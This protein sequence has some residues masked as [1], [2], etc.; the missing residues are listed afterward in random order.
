MAYK[1]FTGKL[2]KSEVSAFTEFTGK[3]D[4]PVA[5]EPTQPAE[6]YGFFDR[7]KQ[8][9]N[10][11]ADIV[12]DKV[13]PRHMGLALDVARGRT[14][15]SESVLMGKVLPEP[16]FNPAEATALS[17]RKYAEMTDPA[18]GASRAP[19][20]RQAGGFDALPD[21][22]IAG[23]AGKLVESFGRG[24]TAG[25]TKVLSDAAGVV[26][27]DQAS[28][29]LD[30][31]TR[32]N[33]RKADIIGRDIGARNEINYAD[34]SRTGLENFSDKYAP[35]ML[36]QLP[37]L[38][39]AL[40]SGGVTVPAVLSGLSAYA[41]AREKGLNPVS[42]AEYATAMGG[43]EAVGEK[44]GGTGKLADAFETALKQ[45]FNKNAVAQLGGLALSTGVKEVPSELVTYSGQSGVDNL[46]NVNP[47]N[48]E[49]FKQGAI[50]TAIVAAGSGAMI[51][52]AGALA[53]RALGG[54]VEPLPAAADI[55]RQKGFLVPD[56]APTVESQPTT[57]I[58]P[59]VE[60]QPTIPVAPGVNRSA[61]TVADPI[62]PMDDAALLAGVPLEEGEAD[63][64]PTVE[65]VTAALAE[66]NA[67]QVDA[68]RVVPEAPSELPTQ[69]PT[70]TTTPTPVIP[71]GTDPRSTLAG[72]MAALKE[73]ATVAKAAQDAQNQQDAQA[74]EQARVTAEQQR[75]SEGDYRQSS[76][77]PTPQAGAVPSPQLVTRMVERAKTTF[78]KNADLQSEQAYPERV[79]YGIINSTDVGPDLLSAARTEL[80]RRRGTP[81][82]PTVSYSGQQSG[83]TSLG[84]APAQGR[85][86]GA[87][88][89]QQPTNVQQTGGN[90]GGSATGAPALSNRASTGQGIDSLPLAQAAPADVFEGVQKKVYQKK[91]VIIKRSQR[92]LTY[93]Q[94]VVSKLA[95]M[96]GKTV[97]WIERAS[98]V[99]TDMPNG[100]V[101]SFE[102]E[103]YF[104]DADST[105]PALEILMHEGV[106]ALPDHIR[107]KLKAVVL[108]NVSA[109]GK[110]EFLKQYGYDKE[111]DTIKDEEV[112]AYVVQNVVK[113][114]EFFQD[115]RKALGNKDFAELAK[116]IVGKIKSWFQNPDQFDAE[117]LGKNIANL[118]E[119]HDAA[120]QAYTQ[121]MQEQGLTPDAAVVEGGP[122]FATKP[123]A[124][125]DYQTIQ[126]K[127]GSMT[128]RG[129]VTEIRALMPDGIQGRATKDGIAFTHSDAP[130]VRHAL[131]GNNTAYSRGGQVTEKLALSRDG[132]YLGA[133][134]QF[135]TPGKIPTLRKLLMKLT[136]EGEAGRFWYENS[137][138]AVLHMVGGDKVE[139][140]KFA[141]LLAIYSPQAKVDTNGTFALR[142]WAQYKAGQPISVKT[143]VM[144]SKAQNAL[145]NVDEYWSGEKTGNF[146]TN[147]LRNIDPELAQGATIDMW[148]MRAAQYSND[149]PTKT[150]YAFMENETNRIA[151]ELGWEPQQVQAA[152]W[153]AMKA[154]MEND[155]VKK[156]VE[157]KSEKKGWIHY[158]YPLK[159]GK[160]QK[161]R[162]IDN[163]A[164]HRQNWIDQAMAYDPS[165]NDTQRAKFDFEDSLLRHIGLISFEARPGRN[166]GVLPGIHDA[167]Y[168]RQLEF[169][170]AVQSAMY[171]EDGADMLAA[172][173]GLM[174]Y[175]ET[176]VPGVWQGEVS[177]ST[178]KS[179]AMAPTK[180][181]EGKPGVDAAQKK[182]LNAYAAI[183]G[184]LT[185]QD[186]VGWHRPFYSATRGESNGIDIDMGRPVTPEEAGAT[187]KAVGAWMT[188][189]GKDMV[190]DGAGGKVPWNQRFAFVSSPN[191]IRLI[192]FGAVTNLQLQTV[193]AKTL[194][195]VLPDAV[196]SDW[197]KSDGEMPENN[198]KDH[199]DGSQYIARASAEGASDVLGWARTVLGERIQGVFNEY[200][201][202]YGWGDPG[203]IAFS[204][205]SDRGSSPDIS[206][207]VLR[208]RADS[209]GGARGRQSADG[210]LR[211][212][213]QEVKALP[214]APNV[215]GFHGP[216]PRLVSVAH[217]YADANGINLKRQSEYAKV[218][219]DRA[220]RIADAYEAMPHAPNDPK[221]KA[222]YTNLIR[223]TIAQYEALTAAGYKFWFMDMSRED[224]QEY[225]G[226]PW[227]AMRD[228][229]ANKVMG[230]FPTT[231]GFGSADKVSD[232][233]LETTVTPFKWPS[234]GMNGPM[235]PVLANDL[236]RAVH[237]AFGHGLEGAGFRAEGEENAWQAHSR[238]FTGTAVHAITTETRG[239]NSW[240][241]YGPHGDANKNAKVEDTHFADQKIG[242]MPSWTWTEGV[243]GDAP[244]FSNKAN[245]DTILDAAGV[246]GKERLDILRDLRSGAI[247]EEDLAKA[248]PETTAPVMSNKAQTETDAF[249]KWFGDSKVVDADGKPLASR[250]G[251]VL[252][253]KAAMSEG[254][255]DGDTGNA[256]PL[257]DLLVSK[258]FSLEG[259]GGLEVPSQREVLNGVIA[260]GDNLEV[261][262]SVV[263][264]IPVDVMNILARKNVT[265]E[266]LFSDKA[267]LKELL[268]I[269]SDGS[270][271]TAVKVA[272][273]LVAAVAGVA[274]KRS[275]ISTDPFG[276]PNEGDSTTAASSF[277]EFHGGSIKPTG[278]NGDY[279][280]ANPDIRF[281]RSGGLNQ[282][283]PAPL[284]E[285]TNWQAFVRTMQDKYLHVEAI[286]NTLLA[287]G[288]TVGEQQ[289][290]YRAEERMHG[291]AQEKLIDFGRNLLEPLLEKAAK[292]GIELNE[293][294][295]YAYAR[296]A[297]ERNDHIDTINPALQG[298]GSGMDNATAASIMQMVQLT[299]DQAK[300]D[301]LQKD[302]MKLT[303]ATRQEYLKSGLISQDEYDGWT[304]TY[305]NYVPLRG[306]ENVDSEGMAKPGA[307]SGLSVKGK[308]T[309]KALGRRSRAGDIIE[310]IVAEHERAVLRGERN[311][312]AKTL[313]NLVQTNPDPALWEVQPRKRKAAFNRKTGLVV[314]QNTPDTADSVGAKVG[315]QQVYIKVKDPLLLRALTNEGL[316]KKGAL[317]GTVV[318]YLGMYTNLLRNTLTRYNPVFGAVNAVRDA[319]MGALSTY[320]TLGAKGV[321]LYAKYYKQAFAAAGRH[322]WGSPNMAKEMDRWLKEMRLAGGTTSGVFMR[323][324]NE[325]KSDLRTAMLLGGASPVG[326]RENL[327]VKS[328][329]AVK[330]AQAVGRVLEWMGA[331]SEDAARLAAYRA[332]R[333]LGKTPA[334][335]ASIAKNL[336]TNFNRS[337]EWGASINGLYL[338]FNAGVQG[339]ARLG[340]ALKNPKVRYV[341]AAGTAAAMA[342]ALAGAAAGGEDDDGVPYW[343]QIPDYEKERNL[344]IMLPPGLEMDGAA[345]VGK[346]GKYIKIP[347]QYGLNVFMTFGYQL[348][349]LARNM[350][351]PARGVT[352]GKAA[353]NMT[354]VTLGSVNPFGGSLDP[355]EP[356]Q[357]GM[358]L[359]PTVGDTALQL[360]A[361]VNA[362]GKPVGPAKGPYDTKP[363]S[364]TY[365]ATQAGSASQRL[366]EWMNTAT[367]GNAGRS[368]AI[369]V[370]PGTLDNAVRN[371]AGGLGMFAAAMVNLPIKYWNAPEVVS[372]RDVPYWKN[373]YGELD[374]ATAVSR[375]YENRALASKELDTAKAEQKL[376]IDVE[377]TAEQEVLQEMARTAETYTKRMSRIRK[378]EIEVALDSDMATGT[379][380]LNRRRLA[381][382]RSELAKEYNSTFVSE[383]EAVK[384]AK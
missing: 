193:V 369:D 305:Q 55:A 194:D 360:M 138:K 102:G 8:G 335:A 384:R 373:V 3:L 257:A 280:P 265:P 251:L 39:I 350:K 220:K 146:V 281:S 288:G 127:D 261:L 307:G 382:E 178:Q 279:D 30:L 309:F 118:Q 295:A 26:G 289:N 51:G 65:S 151:R 242:I 374:S 211:N 48:A 5:A 165:T 319:P 227:N 181:T 306:F 195:P 340:Q 282:P 40:L 198:W 297:Q 99:E 49:Q 336:T 12:S 32:G 158:E 23:N 338:F 264:L 230:V 35:Q 57:P 135:N 231:D 323:D 121:A 98:G 94:Q 71:T 330:G 166:S 292:Y 153:V 294:A 240:L 104:M 187:E 259:L 325:I 192:N 317:Q 37:Q 308:E 298:N 276:G 53:T 46:Y 128:V 224:N 168:D 50:D 108:K 34:T 293:L 171:N 60:S 45:G 252:A 250:S 36:A 342:V 210:A 270:V 38:G 22:S 112:T 352:P 327:I 212:S 268:S 95:A 96:S 226:S 383:M 229:R 75:L 284:T 381:L 349:D 339:T 221:V 111:S 126:N 144:D 92:P 156:A 183:L 241:N 120:V 200:S 114:P 93:Q 228:I 337:G 199:P 344:I 129:D 290:V 197:F 41:D 202:K 122:V 4:E 113:N 18:R 370:M 77:T 170:N 260:L 353:I 343:D 299:G 91:A 217:R 355:R 357:V 186:G 173:L 150:Q 56:A 310:T 368:G 371:T 234:G 196:A 101:N 303:E 206:D 238:L 134:E 354:S 42:A 215:P 9:M 142:A 76:A 124:V 13:L 133:P 62:A 326:L 269:D 33:M 209:G 316:D 73:R 204:N 69:T 106:H 300:F 19:S 324:V 278:N 29:A 176:N 130:R 119:V 21:R 191:G 222:A 182:A 262:R 218:D 180:G 140:R 27:L 235:K 256:K 107:S 149:A 272:D 237:D 64:P 63:A 11:A 67:R 81:K 287:N 84:V 334:E 125:G 378:E 223:Q 72:E 28:A 358:A 377:Y 331:T 318:E 15:S 379:K 78:A 271:S 169:Q 277:D 189:N 167:S 54:A 143:G 136:K 145:D 179:T 2:D 79:L 162:K 239:Q 52:G 364:E 20:M 347:V 58:A 363:D 233:P 283:R 253:R 1:E 320:D 245:T 152:I 213:A 148:M 100:F 44:L 139:A 116:V 147:L 201:E 82:Q 47:V 115:L 83:T 155:G 247:T 296:H 17:N 87:N 258:T 304:S 286:Q 70:P 184:Y 375:F 190:D 246:T 322:E 208:G 157:A 254:R 321:A 345:T 160:P 31:S 59:T 236:F 255:P 244:A 348:A 248:Y 174:I 333:E 311:I 214:G 164:L 341:L 105:H 24:A 131:E 359:L 16:E 172:K 25:A 225:A 356:V 68:S 380:L 88:G 154:R 312:V 219:P 249:K 177:P 61:P 123:I 117:F 367:G 274:A 188:A 315:G 110:A 6:E 361:G 203:T 43:F 66:S 314:Y 141:A 243:V 137:S 365:N 263:K 175:K 275:S 132:K 329:T 159:N 266:M 161:T 291:R 346:K 205:K 366:A 103:H 14:G 7:L 163:E 90:P 185:K 328:A 313:L 362:F 207:S 74:A 109:T 351:D 273:A 376:D 80:D 301:E 285:E 85:T 216:D 89:L 267:M 232:N 372:P 86:A 10:D 97:T 332:A 302:L